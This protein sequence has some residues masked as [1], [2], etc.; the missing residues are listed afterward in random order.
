[1]G[2]AV[3]SR[4]KATGSALSGTGIGAGG[5][6]TARR[7]GTAGWQWSIW[8]TALSSS[9]RGGDRVRTARASRGAPAP[10]WRPRAEASG[11][12]SRAR[13]VRA[14]ARA[15][16]ATEQ[17]GF[18]RPEDHVTIRLHDSR[19]WL[20]IGGNAELHNLDSREAVALAPGGARPLPSSLRS[21]EDCTIQEDS[22]M[23]DEH[24]T[25]IAE[26]AR[27]PNGGSTFLPRSLPRNSRCADHPFPMA[28]GN[29]VVTASTKR[30][31]ASPR[32]GRQGRDRHYCEY[33]EHV[34][35]ASQ[36]RALG[37]DS[38]EYGGLGFTVTEYCR[39][40]MSGTGQHVSA[41]SQ[42]PVDR[43]PRT[44]SFGSRGSHRR[45]AALRGRRD[46]PFRAHEPQSVPSAS[47]ARRRPRRRD[48]S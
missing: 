20:R 31:S 26:Q 12:A 24:D 33:P 22:R 38:N 29:S 9:R 3:G 6:A 11:P 17:R 23:A 30:W 41:L 25:A 8:A 43:R 7:T 19:P 37:M 36:T 32:G 1:M 40:Q 15:R 35:T 45:S 48:L 42:R 2:C 47:L 21:N 14:L 5:P 18:R 27:E 4:R 16:L 10:G 39:E 28:A 46:L 44:S 34:L 13:R